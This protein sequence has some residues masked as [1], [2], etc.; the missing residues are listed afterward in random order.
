MVGW[1]VART[2]RDEEGRGGGG[3]G[4][5]REEKEKGEEEEEKDEEKDEKE[6]DKK[7]SFSTYLE[8]AGLDSDQSSEYYYI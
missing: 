7:Y 2:R 4:E 6:D 5:G 3:E 8:P 1:L